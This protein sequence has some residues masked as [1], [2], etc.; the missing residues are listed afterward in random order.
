MNRSILLAAGLVVSGL[1]TGCATAP[2][3]SVPA[4]QAWQDARQMIVVVTPGWNA[5]QATLRRYHR[6]AAD[7]AWI[8]AGDAAPVVLGRS[9]SAWGSGLSPAQTDGPQKREGDGRNPAGVFAIGPAFGA[10]PTLATG[11]QYLPMIASSWCVDVSGSPLYN[12]IVDA[13]QVGA[14]AV[15]GA[16]EHMRLDLLKADDHRYKE[17]FVIEHNADGVA[18]GG[19]CIF[20]HLWG[21]PDQTTSGCTAMAEATMDTLLG[22]LKQEDHPVFVL[23][24]KAEYARLQRDWNLPTP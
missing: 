11:L 16:S 24:P 5:T 21:R 19:S 7:G 3:A 14:D 15:K 9:G 23:L 10:A 2:N 22:W 13:Q 6:D 12:R 1:F 20:A 17:G 4:P 18:N 8:A